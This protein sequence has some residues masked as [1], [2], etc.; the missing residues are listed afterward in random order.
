MIYCGKVTDAHKFPQ[1]TIVILIY[2]KLDIWIKQK[3]PSYLICNHPPA[4]VWKITT[5]S[6]V[7][8]LLVN[9]IVL[10]SSPFTKIFI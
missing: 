4:M 9:L 7:P 6:S 8:I 5:S 2:L 1:L 3:K 10:I